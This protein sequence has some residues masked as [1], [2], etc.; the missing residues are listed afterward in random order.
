MKKSE[1]LKAVCEYAIDNQDTNSEAYV[2]MME[3]WRNLDEAISKLS[4]TEAATKIE[5]LVGSLEYKA[6]RCGFMLGVE[7]ACCE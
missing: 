1:L 3:T 5:M 4:D 7:V 6:Q 2:S